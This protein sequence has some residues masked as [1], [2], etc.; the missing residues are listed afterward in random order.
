MPVTDLRDQLNQLLKWKRVSSS[1][2]T[3]IHELTINNP[4]IPL[5]S[6]AAPKPTKDTLADSSPA[7]I[8][9]PS[10]DSSLTDLS[11]KNLLSIIANMAKSHFM[12]GNAKPPT[13]TTA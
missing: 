1:P 6:R 9:P 10:V 11:Q 4:A 3:V 7:T 2:N 13:N 8:T 5:L 12:P